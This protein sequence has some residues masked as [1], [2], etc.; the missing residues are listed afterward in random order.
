MLFS[1]PS[2][3]SGVATDDAVPEANDYHSRAA[4]ASRR[5]GVIASVPERLDRLWV[6]VR[7]HDG[8]VSWSM[9]QEMLV[10]QVLHLWCFGT[11]VR[12]SS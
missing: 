8:R 11:C 10:S 6:D 9:R 2:P 5:F 1:G 4:E 3:S 12:T 7:W